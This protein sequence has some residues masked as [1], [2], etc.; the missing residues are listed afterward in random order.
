MPAIVSEN[1]LAILLKA[2][3]SEADIRHSMLVAERAIDTSGTIA[4]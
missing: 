3:L 2:G 1:D 4:R